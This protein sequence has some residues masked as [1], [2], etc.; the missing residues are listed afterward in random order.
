MKIIKIK[1]YR[2]DKGIDF[3]FYCRKFFI[4]YSFFTSVNPNPFPK[5]LKK[6][7]S[8]PKFWKINP[9]PI[10]LK[11]QSQIGIPN[12]KFWKIDPD[13]IILENQSQSQNFEKSISIPKFWKID[14][15]P[16]I[17]KNQSQSQIFAEPFQP[18]FQTGFRD[19][20]ILTLASLYRTNF[21]RFGPISENS[22][23]TYAREIFL[24]FDFQKIFNINSI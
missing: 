9:N 24:G 13:P 16:I 15:N 14:P 19:N 20:E 8:I 17:L 10:I 22:H 12:P 5:I 4:Q 21:L 11:N 1:V 6:S 23:S 2:D 18:L 3:T 7:I